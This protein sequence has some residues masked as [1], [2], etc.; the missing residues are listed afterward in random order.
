MATR[1]K[2]LA[3]SETRFRNMME[4]IPQI[5]W[6]NTIKGKVDYYNQRWYDYTGLNRLKIR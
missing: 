2:A 6:T 1:T 4:T 5:A 3:E